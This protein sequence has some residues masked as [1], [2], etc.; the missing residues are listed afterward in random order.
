ME[1]EVPEVARELVALY[2]PRP[3]PTSGVLHVTS[4]ARAGDGQLH[5][6]AIGPAAPKSASDFFVLNLARACANA[7]LTSGAVLRAEP[8]LRHE[9]QGP[10]APA[11]ERY[12]AALGKL[13]A[14]LCAILTRG[15]ELPLEHPVWTDG[16]GKLV[17]TTPEAAP[18]LRSSLGAR[19]QV[20]GLAPLDAAV[21]CLFL[22]ARGSELVSIE[23]GPRASAVLY[24]ARET[25][26]ELWLSI[27]E[28]PIDERALGGPL[29]EPSALFGGRTCLADTVRVEE[30][31]RWRFQRWARGT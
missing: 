25:V 8:A 14:P 29:A 19:A 16:T 31:G 15:A 12:R 5:A 22:R 2:G 3:L 28:E 30:S 9:L 6:I 21:A 4:A 7:I 20:V 23:A 26:D 13:G 17:L 24:R 27:F 18:H 1:D 11:L 10:W